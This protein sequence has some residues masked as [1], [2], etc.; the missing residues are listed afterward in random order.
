MMTSLQS[1]NSKSKTLIYI[2]SAILYIA[3]INL[4]YANQDYEQYR[5]PI[6][7]NVLESFPFGYKN[8]KGEN[9]GTY[10]EYLHKLEMASNLDI[11]P[12]IV[13]KARVVKYLQLGLSDGAI[14]FKSKS[15][16]PYIQYVSLIRGVPIV[17]ATRADREISKYEDL[18]Q[19]ELVGIFRSGSISDRF[20]ND[21][22]INK[23]E[24]ASYPM[25]LEM[26]KKNRVQAIV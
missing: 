2:V 21:N 4:A 17:I 3:S 7:F 9:V 10:W 22:L 24:I 18:H 15:L 5:D 12:T 6:K 13:P 23:H 25:M 19:L 16:E 14:L 20:D 8:D 26:L 11:E 1:L